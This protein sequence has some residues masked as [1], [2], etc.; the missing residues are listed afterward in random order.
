MRDSGCWIDDMFF[1]TPLHFEVEGI[2]K[3]VEDMSDFDL[4]DEI[5]YLSEDD[6]EIDSILYSYCTTH[7]LSEPD[8]MIL[9]WYYV[10][11]H[12]EDYLVIDEIEEW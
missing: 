10:L 3:E 12:I 1:F 11:C 9:I 2:K 8:R 4:V 5:A 7:V 6:A